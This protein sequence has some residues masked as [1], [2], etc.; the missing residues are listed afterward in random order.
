M[1]EPTPTKEDVWIAGVANRIL[2]TVD[3]ARELGTDNAVRIRSR[4]GVRAGRRGVRTAAVIFAVVVLVRI[5]DAYL[6]IG[7]GVG[8]ATWAAHLFIGGLLAIV[9][10][11]CWAS[12]RNDNLRRIGIAV[13]IDVAIVVVV[14]CYAIIHSFA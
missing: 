9:G 8:D 6:P 4:S 5:A 13:G 14:V 7:A 11:G 3:R 1:A 12:R 2:D 10:F